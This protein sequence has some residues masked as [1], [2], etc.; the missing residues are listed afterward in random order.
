VGII[1]SSGDGSGTWSVTKQRYPGFELYRT[2]EESH[3]LSIQT[4]M[5]GAETG[6]MVYSH[7]HGHGHRPAQQQ[8]CKVNRRTSHKSEVSA[9]LTI[10]A[11]HALQ[12]HVRWARA[13]SRTKI[14]VARTCSRETFMHACLQ[15]TAR[16]D[17]AGSCPPAL[18][19]HINDGA[20]RSHR[21]APVFQQLCGTRL[22]LFND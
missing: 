18:H 16:W 4:R 19:E 2:H 10:D 7:D 3:L 6:H 13:S 14:N 8:R 15:C 20:A 22:F 9:V 1:V 21:V 12:M 11:K 5:P 17:A